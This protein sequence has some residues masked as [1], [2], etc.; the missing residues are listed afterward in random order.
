MTQLVVIALND[1]W[2]E[3]EGVPEGE[4]MLCS[5]E[6]ELDLLASYGT[7]QEHPAKMNSLS[8]NKYF[9]WKRK[10]KCRNLVLKVLFK[11]YL[12]W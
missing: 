3:K 11:I 7:M 6:L 10:K 9:E 4:R 1:R 12:F 8:F 2:K 5:D